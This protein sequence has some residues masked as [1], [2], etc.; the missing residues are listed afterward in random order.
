MRKIPYEEIIAVLN[1][2]SHPKYKEYKELRQLSKVLTFSILYGSSN[3][4]IAMQLNLE[5]QE[6]EVLIAMYFNTFP[7]VKEYIEKSHKFALYNQFS[8]TPLGQRKRQ[9]GT[10][11]CFKSTAAF[12]GSLRN[13]QNVIIQSA[14]STVGL[15]TFTE[16][17]RVVKPFGAIC[18]CTVN[19]GGVIS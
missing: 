6:A 10:Y 8:I 4:G 13:S 5:K 1:D 3:A 11:D 16:V 2:S 7:K 14:T 15:A 17:N 9:F 12:N 19:V 18:T